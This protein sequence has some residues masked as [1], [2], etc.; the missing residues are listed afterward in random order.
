MT[1]PKYPHNP[2][3]HIDQSEETGAFIATSPDV[4]G[5]EAV[6]QSLQKLEDELISKYIDDLYAAVGE[7]PP[8]LELA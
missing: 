4:P 5:F 1:N 8:A 2:R 3:I 7:P 6:S